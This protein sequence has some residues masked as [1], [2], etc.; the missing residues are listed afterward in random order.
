MKMKK[1]AFA[2]IFGCIW[3]GAFAQ[4]AA[5]N[6]VQSTAATLSDVPQ[7]TPAP[8]T[9]PGK[10]L[11]STTAADLESLGLP[12]ETGDLPGTHQNTEAS[13]PEKKKP[14]AP[15]HQDEE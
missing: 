1:I 7:A 8:A 13:L 14:L 10:E 6:T 15:K 2:L 9:A 12:A 4:E 3:A 11:R 5:K